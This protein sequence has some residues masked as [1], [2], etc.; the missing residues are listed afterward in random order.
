MNLAKGVR[1]LATALVTAT[2]AYASPTYSQEKAETAAPANSS[3]APEGIECTPTYCKLPP[4]A[5]QSL[6]CEGLE[7]KVTSVE[8]NIS[9]TDYMLHLQGV[10]PEEYGGKCTYIEQRIIAGMKDKDKDWRTPEIESE[11]TYTIVNPFWSPPPSILKELKKKHSQ[12]WV[13]KMYAH[14]DGI[15]QYPG[16]TNPLGKVKF[17]FPNNQGVL[18]HGTPKKSHSLFDYEKREFSHGCIRIEDEVGFLKKLVEL[19]GTKEDCDDACLDRLLEKGITKKL[20]FKTPVKISIK[21]DR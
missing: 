20:D 18:V 14:K 13:D 3:E 7:D 4:K 6:S 12:E 21:R 11:I 2:L 16:P 15:Y 1:Y 5:P 17:Y 9:L 10:L 8:V 19:S